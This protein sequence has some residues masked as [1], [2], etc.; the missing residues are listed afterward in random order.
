[1]DL[2]KNTIKNCWIFFLVENVMKWPEPVE[3]IPWILTNSF[4]VSSHL[5]RLFDELS[6][7]KEKS[8]QKTT[9]VRIKRFLFHLHLQ[10]LKKT[11]L[12][13][14]PRTFPG[15]A[16]SMHNV[17]NSSKKS[18][19]DLWKNKKKKDFSSDYFCNL[20]DFSKIFFVKISPQKL[21]D[22]LFQKSVKIRVL[23]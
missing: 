1:M 17:W 3:Q 23:V 11:C 14:N 9:V 12:I 18:H 10:H 4:D 6:W 5:S 21:H 16:S 20:H 8:E 22:F 15:V 19:C 2:W 7:T 13:C